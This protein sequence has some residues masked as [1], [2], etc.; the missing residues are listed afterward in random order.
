MVTHPNRKHD[1]FSHSAMSVVNGVRAGPVRTYLPYVQN[2]DNFHLMLNTKVL[3]A[4]RSGSK[5]TGV[6]VENANGKRSTIKIKNTGRVI[7]ASGT[8]SSPRTLWYS[9]IGRPDTL[10]S[11]RDGQINIALPAEEDWINLP[12]GESLR[13][14]N[15]CRLHFET[16]HDIYYLGTEAFS[17]PSDRFVDLYKTGSGLFA[18]TNNRGHFW[19]SLVLPQSS[20]RTRFF[21]GIMLPKA[22]NIVEFQ[23]VLSHG[24]TSSGQL[25]IDPNTGATTFI[26]APVIQTPADKKA[27]A[28]FIDRMIAM[29]NADGSPMT[30]KP[31]GWGKDGTE[32]AANTN[33]GKHYVGT[34]KMGT[35]DGRKGGSAVV[36]VNTKVYGTDNLHVVDAS[37]HPDLP[38]GNTQ[39]ITMVAAEQAAAK[40]AALDGFS[41]KA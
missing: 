1:I 38:T 37:I 36:D 15:Q 11:I 23:M 5:I 14:H 26:Q 2:L 33:P 12:V 4:V 24:S 6:R 19:S 21:Q 32:I 34:C 39:A 9:G 29:S 3:K 22:N 17:E 18:Q 10:T 41:L 30:F 27:Y 13:N 31:S 28:Q 16:K 25:G 7:I 40:I 35:D 8:M 20:G